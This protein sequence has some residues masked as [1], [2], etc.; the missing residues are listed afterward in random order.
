MSAVVLNHAKRRTSSPAANGLSHNERAEPVL[1]VARRAT[2][3][4]VQSAMKGRTVTAS[5]ADSARRTRA[6]VRDGASAPSRAPPS[7][8]FPCIVDSSQTPT[9]ALEQTVVERVSRLR[10][11]E[12][13]EHRRPR[14]ERPP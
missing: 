7:A 2:T 14:S 10:Q 8:L 6:A 11:K 5:S 1:T 12:L 9:H 13:N 3:M 4:A